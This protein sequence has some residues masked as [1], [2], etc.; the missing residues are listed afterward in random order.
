M[1]HLRRL[2]ESLPDPL[3]RV[4]DQSLLASEAGTGNEH[5]AVTRD[6]QGRYALVYSAA[7]RPFTV[8]LE[9][10]AGDKLRAA[11]FDP[12]E[13][14][15]RLLSEIARHGT[16]EFTPPTLG[17]GQDWILVLNDASRNFQ[18][19]SLTQKSEVSTAE[20]EADESTTSSNTGTAHNGGG[21]PGAAPSR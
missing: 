7:G 14:T 2:M 10:L 9:N 20:L 4:P 1:G 15:H 5:I 11:W 8:K 3:Q 21:T 19:P 18:L 13:G 16:R 17:E 6:A 12:R